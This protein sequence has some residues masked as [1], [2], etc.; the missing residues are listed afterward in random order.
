[1]HGHENG[2]NGHSHLHTHEHN[3][4]D[5]LLALIDSLPLPQKVIADA[6]AVYMLIAG[7]ESKAH[8]KPVAQVHFHEL[9]AMDAV[10]DIVGVC[11]LM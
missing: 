4:I 7:A 9:G 2:L 6:K 1:M 10:W 8:G 11:M 3:S 5:A